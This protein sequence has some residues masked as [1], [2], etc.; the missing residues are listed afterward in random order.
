MTTYYFSDLNSGRLVVGCDIHMFVEVKYS[1]GDNN[2]WINFDHHTKNPYFDEYRDTPEFDVIELH[3][4]R[5]YLAFEQLCGVRAYT[6]SPSISPP[7]GVPIDISAFV[8]QHVESWNIDGHSHSFVT[9]EEIRIYRANLKDL[10]FDGLKYI[11]EA[12][13]L[14]AIEYFLTPEGVDPKNIRIVFFFDN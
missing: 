13:E 12:L 14:R 2:K 1:F 7:R 5:N 6:E 4:V 9:L 8:K 11:H 3:D 10:S